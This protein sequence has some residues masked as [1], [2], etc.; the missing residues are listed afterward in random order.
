MD[1]INPILRLYV[2]MDQLSIYHLNYK[3][4]VF[5]DFNMF[6]S[7]SPPKPFYSIIKRF[8]IDGGYLCYMVVNPQCKE[9]VYYYS[10]REFVAPQ[11]A[12]SRLLNFINLVKDMKAKGWSISNAIENYGCIE[13]D[14][15]TFVSI[16]AIRPIESL[17]YS[18]MDGYTMMKL[19]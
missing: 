18:L 1:F 17:S 10:F 6:E 15:I 7:N 5:W 11:V 19:Q 4:Y 16:D 3:R 12:R 8:T 14:R 2:E 9:T 13:N